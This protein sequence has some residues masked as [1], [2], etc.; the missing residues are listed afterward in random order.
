MSHSITT[1]KSLNYN[2]NTIGATNDAED[3]YFQSDYFQPL[4]FQAGQIPV[5]ANIATTTVL[6]SLYKSTIRVE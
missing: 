3:E 1:T 5:A 4:Y 2:K 6:I